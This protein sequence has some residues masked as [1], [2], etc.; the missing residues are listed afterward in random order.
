MYLEQNIP[1][2]VQQS[3]GSNQERHMYEV[4]WWKGNL[5]LETDSFG[6]GLGAGL[7]HVRERVNCPKPEHH[8]IQSKNLSTIDNH[9]N[10]IEREAPLQLREITLVLLC[11]RSADNHK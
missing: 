8:T 3:K 1:G 10:N 9:Y 7:L 11:Q 4:L 2:A 6:S 5:Y